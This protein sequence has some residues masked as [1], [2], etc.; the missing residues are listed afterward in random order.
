MVWMVPFPAG[1]YGD[2]EGPHHGPLSNAW[3]ARLTQQFA[4]EMSEADKAPYA[5][6]DVSYWYSVHEKFKSHSDGIIPHGDGVPL[7]PIQPHEPP[8]WFKYDKGHKSP[9]CIISFPGE[10]LGCSESF[11]SLI[12]KLEPGRHRFFPI[13]V[14]NRRGPVYAEPHHLM[15]INQR[16]ENASDE[17]KAEEDW[18]LW[19]DLGHSQRPIF[20]SDELVTSVKAAGMK[21]PRLSTKVTA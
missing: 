6:A 5:G 11:K 20:L 4:D 12:E 7:P 14:R 18:H 9:A 8:T 15:I 10:L 17:A 21:M 3:W 16:I 1:P 13:D 19:V 2:Y